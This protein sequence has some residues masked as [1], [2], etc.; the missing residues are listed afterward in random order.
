MIKRYDMHSD[1]YDEGGGH[2]Y[3]EIRYDE[4][5]NGEWVKYDDIKHL[6]E[7][8]DNS[9]YTKCCNNCKIY[10]T[11]KCPL[12]TIIGMTD[13]WDYDKDYCSKHFAQS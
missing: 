12:D 13:E 11:A 10:K 1:I 5:K 9:D 4:D 7:R 6:L 8:S 2:Q 3:S